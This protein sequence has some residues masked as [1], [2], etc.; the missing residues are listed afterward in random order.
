MAAGWKDA[1]YWKTG[2]YW[3]V[4]VVDKIKNFLVQCFLELS[5]S[6]ILHPVTVKITQVWDIF[7][8]F[9]IYGSL[10]DIQNT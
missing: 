7:N 2:L 1:G 9:A 10:K 4:D 6:G 5:W 8:M 3:R